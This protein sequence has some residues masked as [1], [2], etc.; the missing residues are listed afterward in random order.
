MYHMAITAI[1]DVVTSLVERWYH[2][3][4]GR[5]VFYDQTDRIFYQAGKP[6][7]PQ[8]LFVESTAGFTQEKNQ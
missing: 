7:V 4:S 6:A 1:K 2:D 8:P 3:E 5:E